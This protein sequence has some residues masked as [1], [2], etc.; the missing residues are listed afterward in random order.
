MK[1]I[2]AVLAV[3]VLAA[4]SQAATYSWTSGTIYS[5]DGKATSSSGANPVTAYVFYVDAATWNGDIDASAFFNEDGS[6]KS[7]LPT[8]ATLAG[9]K[10]SAGNG[11]ANVTTDVTGTQSSPTYAFVFYVDPNGASGKAEY[12]AAKASAYVDG[13]GEITAT[14]SQN[15]GVGTF[16][17]LAVPEPTTVALLALGLAVFGLKRK[18]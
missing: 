10:T 16:T 9:S 8:G 2:L 7:S 17:A 12:L 13:M 15:Y 1:K 5:S 4:A 18:V 11:M 14:P 6:Q 3:A